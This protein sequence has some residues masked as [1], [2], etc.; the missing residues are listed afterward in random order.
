M[1]LWVGLTGGIGSG[2]S[3]VCRLFGDLGVPIIDA[4]EVAREVVAPGQP[5]L[6]RI[7]R[8][9]GEQVLDANGQLR[10]EHLRSLIFRDPDRKKQL[11]AILHPI[12]NET[13]FQRA[14]KIGAPY[15]VICIPLLLETGAFKWLHRILVVDTPIE[16]QIV[17]VMQRD[18]ATKEEVAAI[19]R[20]QASRESRLLAAD[21]IL[22][23]DSDLANLAK[24][25][26]TLHRRYLAF[27]TPH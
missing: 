2:K 7:A 25:V 5:T 17:H 14:K 10:R 19:M 12:I 1:T 18:S 3:T 20:T 6:A 24:Q 15:C 11:E 26:E 9:F 8:E 22:Y 4:D 13:L 16:R 21:D 27:P 23:N